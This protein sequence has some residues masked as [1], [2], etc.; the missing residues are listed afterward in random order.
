MN[1]DTTTITIGVADQG[2]ERDLVRGPTA[3]LL[4]NQQQRSRLK[5]RLQDYSL[6]IEKEISIISSMEAFIDIVFP[7]IIGSVPEA[8][9]V[10]GDFS[11]LI[12][13]P[14]MIK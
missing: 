3:E 14:P 1:A 12:Y 11:R 8:S 6:K 4:R 13:K 2:V 10:L 9:L 7:L 5:M